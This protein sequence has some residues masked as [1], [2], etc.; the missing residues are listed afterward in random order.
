MHRAGG[1]Q[2]AGGAGFL[3]VMVRAVPHDGAGAGDA[4]CGFFNACIVL[5]ISAQATVLTVPCHPTAGRQQAA[6]GAGLFGV[7]VRAVPHD[8]AGAGGV[9]AGAGA[10]RR[11]RQVRLR[12]DACQPGASPH[13]S[14]QV[15]PCAICDAST[16]D[17]R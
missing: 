15:L 16:T 4:A 3:G 6:G 2:A 8:G 10:A 12:G 11:L 13:Q 17:L 9:G 5:F 1:Q 7:V 14:D